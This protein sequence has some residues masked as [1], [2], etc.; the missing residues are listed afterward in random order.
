M[1][2]DWFSDAFGKGISDVNAKL[3]DEAWF[4]RAQRPTG[5]SGWDRVLEEKS[6]P[7]KIQDGAFLDWLQ[8]EQGPELEADRDEPA[9]PSPTHDH[10]IDR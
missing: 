3:I 10:G 6:F 4:G 5:Q 1:P 8:S 2:A 9:V 7:D